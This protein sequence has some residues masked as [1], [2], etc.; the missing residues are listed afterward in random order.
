MSKLKRLVVNASYE[1]AQSPCCCYRNKEHLNPQGH[2]CID[3]REHDGA[4]LLS[5][6]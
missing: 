4:E 5:V 6:A 2:R 3:Y 1:I